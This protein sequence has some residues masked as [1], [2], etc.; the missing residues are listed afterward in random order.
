MLKCI[1]ELVIIN[2][3]FWRRDTRVDKLNRELTQLAVQP[4]LGRFDF[5]TR[6]KLNNNY[7]LTRDRQ[8]NAVGRSRPGYPELV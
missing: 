4:T 5:R 2:K 6:N 1:R 7:F 8:E 3:L